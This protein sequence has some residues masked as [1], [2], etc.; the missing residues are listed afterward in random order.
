MINTPQ[1][2]G[3]LVFFVQEVLMKKYPMPT[4]PKL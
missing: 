1:D 3:E 4:L 2:N